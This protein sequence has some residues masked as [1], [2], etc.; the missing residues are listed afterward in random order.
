MASSNVE[1]LAS[2]SDRT[3]CKLL[4]AGFGWA[5]KLHVVDGSFGPAGYN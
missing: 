2:S 4:Q 3:P 5:G 1:I